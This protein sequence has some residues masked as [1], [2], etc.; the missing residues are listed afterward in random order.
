MDGFS[1]RGENNKQLNVL[2]G[3][4]EPCK[5]ILENNENFVTGFFRDNC[6][7]TGQDDF[8]L[9]TVCCVM[10]KEFLA[11]SKS[12]GND[13]ST[14][15]PAYNFFGLNEGDFWC[16][17]ASRWKEAFNS[18]KAPKVVIK[19]TNIATLS[20]INLEDLQDYSVD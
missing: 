11:F 17:C 4:L 9:H 6:C 7:N 16:L 18:G 14:P 1:P 20:I 19:S 12:V 5:S 2:G 10:T 13:L 8:G 3:I 15:I